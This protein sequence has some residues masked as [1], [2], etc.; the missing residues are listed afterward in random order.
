MGNDMPCGLCCVCDEPLD[1]SDMAV[2]EHCAQGFHWGECGGW[3]GMKRV[4]ERCAA[5]LPKRR[6]D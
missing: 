1:F 4:C 6:E 2:C 5:T 3:E